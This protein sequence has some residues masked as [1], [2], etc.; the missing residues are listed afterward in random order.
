MDDFVNKIILWDSIEIM[1]RI[2]SNSID[3]IFADPPYTMQLKWNLYR[4]DQTRVDCV[5]DEWDRFSS[6][7]EYDTFTYQWLKE[8]KRILKKWNYMG[9]RFL[10]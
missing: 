2:P 10:S 7:E 6:F 5:N 9:N 8:C 1:K 3:M 4:P